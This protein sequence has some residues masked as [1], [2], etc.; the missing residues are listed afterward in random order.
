MSTAVQGALFQ[1]RAR[2]YD[3][4]LQ[5]ALDGPNIPPSVYTALVDG[6]NATC[7]RFIAT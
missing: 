2:N 6:V 4:T 7:R 1:T 3:S 5:R